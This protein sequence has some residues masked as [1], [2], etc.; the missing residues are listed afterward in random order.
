MTDPLPEIAPALQFTVPWF[1]M[2]RFN[3]HTVGSQVLALPAGLQ[4][5]PPK[6]TPYED[7]GLAPLVY[8]DISAAHGVM[9][10]AIQIELAS[11]I[12]VPGQADAVDMRFR[13]TGQGAL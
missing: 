4:Y 1:V 2:A 7:N 12:L 8:F 10:G 11:R 13:A 9:N 6:T 3:T 5:T